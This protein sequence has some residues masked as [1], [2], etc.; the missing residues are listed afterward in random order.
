LYLSTT[1]RH[2]GGVE[3]YNHLFLTLALDGGRW[4][5]PCPSHF[6]PPPPKDKMMVHIG[7]YMDTRAILDVLEKGK[8]SWCSE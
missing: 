2:I 6:T 1:L 5:T 7:G 3:V 8:I 4:S